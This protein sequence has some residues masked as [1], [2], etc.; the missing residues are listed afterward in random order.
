MCYG[1][2]CRFQKLKWNI[3]IQSWIKYCIYSHLSGF[4]N[5]LFMDLLVY[6][7]DANSIFFEVSHGA[8]LHSLSVCNAKLF[9]VLNPKHHAMQTCGGGGMSSCILKPGTIRWLVNFTPWLLYLQ[10]RNSS[11]NRRGD[12]VGPRVS[13]YVVESIILSCWKSNCECLAD[14]LV[15]M[16]SKISHPLGI[17]HIHLSLH[18]AIILARSHEICHLLFVFP[19]DSWLPE[20]KE[21]KQRILQS[22]TYKKLLSIF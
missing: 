7:W 16:L 13:L 22:T 12:W 19:T 3:F 15:T 9:L 18:L 8:S 4:T 5:L 14:S 10:G 6:G 17:W 21:R 2:T 11:T 20:E 1:H